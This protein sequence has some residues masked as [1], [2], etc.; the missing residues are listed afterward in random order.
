MQCLTIPNTPTRLLKRRMQLWSEFLT[1]QSTTSELNPWEQVSRS[2]Y[3]RYLQIRENERTC[4][5]A[6]V[7]SHLSLHLAARNI[8][9]RE[10]SMWF[11]HSD[12]NSEVVAERAE[13][14][15][16]FLSQSSLESSAKSF[17]SL[18]FSL[19]GEN[20]HLATRGA[21]CEWAARKI[22]SR[23]SLIARKCFRSKVILEFHKKSSEFAG[24]FNKILELD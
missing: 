24:I 7:D 13:R 20:F 17:H 16:N 1:R 4:E 11:R 14:I 12:K 21:S 23:S 3:F 8:R 6:L 19:L 5:K 15:S 2:V 22:L 9:V 18:R 10:R